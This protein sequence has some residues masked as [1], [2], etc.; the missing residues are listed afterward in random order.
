MSDLLLPNRRLWLPN[1][2]MVPPSLCSMFM[3]TH[4][5]GFG[6]GLQGISLYDAIS[7]AG[8]TTNLKLAFDAG[9]S[10]SYSGSGQSW[11]D[12]SGNG[13]D[14]FLGADGSATATDPTFNGSAG[15]LSAN[16]YF[17]SDGG[18]YFRYDSANETWMKQLHHDSS[19]FTLLAMAY[20]Q[21]ASNFAV[22]GNLTGGAGLLFHY[23]G[24]DALRILARKAGATVVLD[25]TSDAMSLVTGWHFIALSL[26]EAGGNVSFFY[27][28]GNYAQVSAADTFDAAYTAPDT[29]DPA[30]TTEIGA[31]GNGDTPIPSGARIAMMAAWQGTALSK[32]NLDTL[33]ASLRGRVGL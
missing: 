6:G 1:R 12:R 25:K 5:L 2:E 18:D 7:Q 28:N 14:F 4:L 20:I 19:V 32:A 16:E 30:F 10:V 15:G 13:H 29:S 21:S 9:D 23:N 3:A 17:S 24:S 22:L 31:F 26:S 8:L 11:L 27:R 33:Y